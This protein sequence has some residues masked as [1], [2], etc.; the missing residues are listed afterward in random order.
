MPSA[1]GPDDF[2]RGVSCSFTP[3]PFTDNALSKK[4]IYTTIK[5]RKNPPEPKS[6]IY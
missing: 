4:I 1:H 2:L 6:S 3:P 5:G